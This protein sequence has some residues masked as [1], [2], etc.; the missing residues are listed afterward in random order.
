MYVYNDK[1]IYVYIMI[2]KYLN[3][4]E[5]NVYFTQELFIF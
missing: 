1:N 5:N 4:D 3:A 2:L